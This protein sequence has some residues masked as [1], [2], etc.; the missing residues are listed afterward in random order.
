MEIR[1]IRVYQNG[2]TINAG[3]H[4]VQIEAYTNDG[5]NVARAKPVKGD[6]SNTFATSPSNSEG[7]QRVTNGNLDTS[8]YLYSGTNAST[9]IQVDLGMLYDVAYLKIYNY[10]GDTRAYNSEIQVSRTVTTWTSIYKAYDSSASE[11]LNS[12][13][14]TNVY[15]ETSSGFKIALPSTNNTGLAYNGTAISIKS[16]DSKYPYYNGTQL[17]QVYYNGKLVWKKFTPIP[18]TFTGSILTGYT[19]SSSSVTIPS[20]YSVVSDINGNNIFIEG[21]DYPVTSIGIEAFYGNTTLT[22]ITI[23]S[24]VKCIN[25]LAFQCCVNLATV[26]LSANLTWI[27]Y[28][29][30]AVTNLSGPSSYMYNASYLK[31]GCFAFRK[32][33]YLSSTD[34]SLHTKIKNT[35]LGNLNDPPGF[36]GYYG[37][38]I[39]ASVKCTAYCS[40]VEGSQNSSFTATSVTAQGGLKNKSERV[41]VIKHGFGNIYQGN[42]V[43]AGIRYIISCYSQEAIPCASGYSCNA[44][45]ETWTKHGEFTDRDSSGNMR[46]TAGVTVKTDCILQGAKILLANNT[47]K[48]I[49]DLEYTDLLKVWNFELGKYDYQYPLAIILKSIITN[50][51]RIHLEDGTY[52]DITGQ[53][54]FYDPVHHTI[55]VYGPGGIYE[56]NPEDNYYVMK[57]INDNIYNSTKVISIENISSE[58]PLQS[59]S[60]VTGGTISYFVDNVL[61]CMKT[62]EYV[63]LTEENKFGK[64]FAKDKETC[65]TYDRFKKEIFSHAPKYI[66]LGNNLQYVNYYNKDT[67]GF[68]GLLDPFNY[69]LAPPIKDGKIVCNIGFLED[70]ELIEE[71]HVEDELITLPE[72]KS[73]KY[74]KWYVVGEYREYKPGDI[75]TVN[76]STLIRAI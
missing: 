41:H 51:R 55:R 39:T 48:N 59:Y 11:T 23:P 17:A 45:A 37:C 47:Y 76:F 40:W 60:L 25:K 74:T 49:E 58:E 1:Y 56:I 38:G 53:H 9:Y 57:Y 20:S 21:T 10:F 18:F 66:I 19:G 46:L 22:S 2:N 29:A 36:S 65:Y 26:T 70:K 14:F 68:D 3:N 7:L 75:I 28:C 31:Q 12:K 44:H 32:P 62:I 13:S 6:S 4:W 71:Q 27:G 69:M 54:E 8:Y 64:H 35:H 63:G 50:F 24:S 61:S 73:S 42:S 43:D 5:T 52:I 33:W 34:S 15:F 72:F 67:S 30:F 16:T